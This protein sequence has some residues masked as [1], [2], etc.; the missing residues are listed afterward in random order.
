MA[1]FST[2]VRASAAFEVLNNTLN[3]ETIT[4]GPK[5]YTFKNTLTPTANEVKVGA[6]AKTTLA[7]LV[8]AVNKGAGGG[9]AYAA[10]TT[11]NEHVTVVQDTQY[12][13]GVLTNLATGKVVARLPG[14]LGN[15]IFVDCSDEAKID[16]V[17][18]ATTP[19]A[20]TGGVGSMYLAMDEMEAQ[21]QM[22]SDTIQSFYE[23]RNA[24]IA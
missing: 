2:L 3:N 10:A 18:A 19:E 9:T 11:R 24:T 13:E 15:L 17:A 14:T 1:T 21:E 22:N 12:V 20:L 16:I 4:L 8:A 7:N 6:D 23:I 5:V